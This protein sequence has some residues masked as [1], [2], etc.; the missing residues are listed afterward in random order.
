MQEI[1]TELLEGDWK[2]IKYIEGVLSEEDFAIHKNER[3]SLRDEYNLI[4]I[5]LDVLTA[6][7]GE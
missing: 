1:R 2:T 5:E 3:Q 6:V 7:Q 4:E